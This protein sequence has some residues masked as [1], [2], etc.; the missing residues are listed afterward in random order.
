VPVLNVE[1]IPGID[2][3]KR[4]SRQK[5]R[6][7]K[8]LPPE[9]DVVERVKGLSAKPWVTSVESEF[10]GDGDGL[11]IWIHVSALATRQD[12]SAF[13]FELGEFLADYFQSR[14]LHF[15]W[16]IGI[17]CEG[18]PTHSISSTKRPDHDD[19]V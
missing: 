17:W 10:H 1:R 16:S 12:L 19:Q 18:S 11:A 14:D 8:R 9:D 7:Q 5:K 13:E 4:E 2:M 15:S 3:T 6:H